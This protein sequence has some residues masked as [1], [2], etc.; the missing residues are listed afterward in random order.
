M[1]FP[2][3]GKNHHDGIKNEKNMLT[4]LQNEL[5][6]NPTNPIINVIEREHNAKIK[7][8]NHE[9]GTKQVKDISYELDNDEKYGISVKNH[10]GK[11][12]TFDLINT[13]KNIDPKLK[14]CIADFKK[15]YSQSEEITTELR[16]ELTN[17]FNY[18]LDSLNSKDIYKLIIR[19]KDEENTKFI[20]I[21][22]E[23]N[24][25]YTMIKTSYLHKYCDPNLQFILKTT[26][27][28]KTSRQIW[29]K[30]ENGDEENTNLRIRAHLNNGISALL[31]KSKSNKDAAPCFKIQL[32]KVRTF[33]DNCSDKVCVKY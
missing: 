33:I 5:K 18:Y 29:I 26:R 20:I 2:T 24:K 8:F 10:K 9:G 21:N 19:L 16:E 1:P 6:N 27:K 17:I 32:D 23:K 12:S 3:N 13:T 15:G 30:K 22:D 14:S 11:D 7:Q 28:A 4:Y 25:Q 31:G